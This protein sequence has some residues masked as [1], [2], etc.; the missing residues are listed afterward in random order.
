MQ[1]RVGNRVWHVEKEGFVFVFLNE[2][3][4]PFGEPA[5]EE[6]G[7]G[8]HLDDLLAV[9]EREQGEIVVVLPW[10]ERVDVVAVGNAEELVEALVGRHEFGLVAEVPLAEHPGLV[11]SPLQDFCDGDLFRVQPFFVPGE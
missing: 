11:A 5:R 6:I 7:V 3:H 8:L 10:V 2:L 4:R 1:G 9:E